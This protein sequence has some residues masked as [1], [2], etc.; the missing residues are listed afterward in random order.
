[1]Q[2]EANKNVFQIGYYN[3][4]KDKMVTFI[5]SPETIDITQEQEVVKAKQTIAELDIEKVKISFEEALE[6]AK[7]CREE[8]YKNELVMKSFFI[9]QEIDNIS[10]FNITYLTH[11]FKTIN[12]KINASDGKVVKHTIGVIAEF[13]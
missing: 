8:H 12:I 7:K 11:G 6:T 3:A 2:D 9:I 1:M 10:M 4:S 13:S 5:V